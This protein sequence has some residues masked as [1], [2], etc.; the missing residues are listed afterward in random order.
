[1]EGGK[2]RRKGAIFF[3]PYLGV[4]LSCY[5]GLRKIW[6]TVGLPIFHPKFVCLISLPWGSQNNW[7]VDGSQIRCFLLLGFL[8]FWLKVGNQFLLLPFPWASHYWVSR[9]KT[10]LAML[11]LCLRH[12]HSLNCDR[13]HI[14]EVIT[15]VDSC[16]SCYCFFLLSFCGLTAHVC[17][18]GPRSIKTLT[19]G[20]FFTIPDVVLTPE[21]RHEDP[22]AV[23]AGEVVDGG[24]GG[25]FQ[26]FLASRKEERGKC[27]EQQTK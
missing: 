10:L 22:R 8:I 14:Q 18:F 27:Q 26:A 20:L 6:S 7:P 19:T 23:S 16:R 11:S 25:A 15:F 9:N 4:I 5:L 21:P 17:D 3:G 13:Q 2:K 24:G 12:V 1:M